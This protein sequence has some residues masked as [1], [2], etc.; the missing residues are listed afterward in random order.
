MGDEIIKTNDSKP[1]GF[2][3]DAEA[4][5][6]ELAHEAIRSTFLHLMASIVGLLGTTLAS[7][8]AFMGL[9]SSFSEIRIRPEYVPFVASIFS[10][11]VGL[12][13]IF[14]LARAFYEKRVQSIAHLARRVRLQEAK[15]FELAALDFDAL[16]GAHGRR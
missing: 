8:I 15:L 11:A 3:S 13:M 1:S 2:L 10:A 7:A 14:I 5:K 6:S 4:I 12:A 16:V 9:H